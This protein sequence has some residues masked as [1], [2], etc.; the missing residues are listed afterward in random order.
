MGKWT[1]HCGDRHILQILHTLEIYQLKYSPYETVICLPLKEV[2]KISINKIMT[3]RGRSSKC[4]VME[5]GYQS[6]TI[7]SSIY[8]TKTRKI[9]WMLLF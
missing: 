3:M 7:F 5:L 4:S 2:V 8:R 6:F 9:I 1:I